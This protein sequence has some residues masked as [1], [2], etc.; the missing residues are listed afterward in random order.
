MTVEVKH[1]GYMVV[2]D[3]A[4]LLVQPLEVLLAWFEEVETQ[5]TAKAVSNDGGVVILPVDTSAASISEEVEYEAGISWRH[6]RLTSSNNVDAAA[7]KLISRGMYSKSGLFVFLDAE[8]LWVWDIHKHQQYD[9]LIRALAAGQS[10]NK[11]R[12]PD[13]EKAMHV[14]L[15]GDTYIEVY[16]NE[17]PRASVVQASCMQAWRTV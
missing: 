7:T 12:L 11:A 3:P 2:A 15:V 17:A 14:T 13:L 8:W 6:I 16:A 4:T 9:M 1:G 5:Q 10:P